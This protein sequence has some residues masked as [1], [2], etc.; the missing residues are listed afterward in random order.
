MITIRKADNNDLIYIKNIIQKHY[1]IYN[2]NLNLSKYDSDLKD[3]SKNYKN[4]FWVAL[5]NNEL[6]GSVAIS[7]KKENTAELK[8]MYVKP[9]WHGKNIAQELYEQAENF[10]VKNNFSKIV[11][12]SDV[13]YVRSHYFYKKMGFRQIGTKNFFDADNPYSSILFEKIIPNEQNNDL[14]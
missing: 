11:L 4:R 8:R 3:I 1:K 7:P 5:T 10:A 2:D 12:W 9:L 14:L 13:R 6:I